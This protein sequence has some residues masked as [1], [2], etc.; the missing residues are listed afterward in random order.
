MSHMSEI[1]KIKTENLTVADLPA[2]KPGWDQFTIFA[3]SWDPN[4]ELE[5]G[6]SPYLIEM[7]RYSPTNTSTILELRWFLFMQQRGWHERSDEIGI[8]SWQRIDQAIEILRNKL[9]AK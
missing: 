1:K 6:Q 7:F 9:Q 8:K 2:T 3:L 4:T 5:D